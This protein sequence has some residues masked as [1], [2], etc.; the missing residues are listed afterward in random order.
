MASP[1]I[2]DVHPGGSRDMPFSSLDE[3][4]E[5]L[6]GI[7]PPVTLSQANVISEIADAL[8][9]DGEEN[10]W[11]IAIAQFKKLFRESGGK[12]IKKSHLSLDEQSRRVRDAWY[13]QFAP[14]GQ[15]ID[16]GGYVKEVYSTHAIVEAPEG[17]F[18]YP[19]ILGPEGVQFGEPSKVEMSFVVVKSGITLIVSDGSRGKQSIGKLTDKETERFWEKVNKTDECWLWTA[20]KDKD[21]YGVFKIGGQ[22]QRANRVAYVSVKGPIPD[23]KLICHSCDNAAC[24]RPGHLSVCTSQENNIG[25]FRKPPKETEKSFDVEILKTNQEKQLVYG[26]VLKPD[27]VDSQQDFVS[28]SE[29]EKCAHKWMIKSRVFDKEHAELL[30]SESA[31]P[32]ESYVSPVGFE[33]NGREVKAGS[34]IVVS[35]IASKEL[36]ES[37][38]SGELR[39]FSIRGKGTRKRV[40]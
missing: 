15:N 2:H 4:P 35:H 40:Q 21:G 3:V 7:D 16:S 19:Y 23:G 22:T 1:T 8:K 11:P 29:I 10:P 25:K 17:L 20:A 37:V 13:A 33:M 39:A 27:V 12:W 34:W 5:S 28:A 26:I 14:E 32:V 36:W 30:G 38:K 9:E 24:V 18:A 31:R 6:K